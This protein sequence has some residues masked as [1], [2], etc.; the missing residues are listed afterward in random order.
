MTSRTINYCIETTQEFVQRLKTYE[1]TEPRDS[2]S[3]C[4]KHL[5][6]AA[7]TA[8]NELM[9]HRPRMKSNEKVKESLTVIKQKSRDQ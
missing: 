3:W 5:L 2:E 4:K 9:M 8:V 6:A 7:A 1:K